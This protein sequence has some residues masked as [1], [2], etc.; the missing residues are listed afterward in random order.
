[1]SQVPRRTG[2][3]EM[4][5]L[6]ASFLGAP[7]VGAEPGGPQG[8]ERPQIDSTGLGAFVDGAVANAMTRDHIAG[9]DVAIVSPDTV[10]LAKGYGI[11][12]YEPAKEMTTATLTRVGSLSKT[13]VWIALMQMVE[14][15]R[16][17]LDDPINLHLPPDLKVP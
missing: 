7:H 16:I 3:L 9:V 1:M 6:I 15:H 5:F 4:L 13:I 11:S 12:G 10:L 2:A 14:Q 8:S 17:S